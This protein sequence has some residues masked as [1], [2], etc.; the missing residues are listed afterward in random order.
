MNGLVK[1]ALVAAALTASLAGAGA[2]LGAGV[3]EARPTEGPRCQKYFA[4]FDH[5]YLMASINYDA[6]N[7]KEGDRW[8]AE[9]DHQLNLA[10]WAGCL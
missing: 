8:A 5:A 9:G 3:A 6:G 1:K 10:V 2:G 4:A 7:L